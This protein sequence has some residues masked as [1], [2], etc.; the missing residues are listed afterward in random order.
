M[1]IPL[2]VFFRNIF[3]INS[4]LSDLTSYFTPERPLTDLPAVIN[5]NQRILLKI[6][7][8]EFNCLTNGLPLKDSSFVFLGFEIQTSVRTIL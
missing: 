8:Y 4:I 3:Y 1:N 2:L 6:S 5:N 7:K